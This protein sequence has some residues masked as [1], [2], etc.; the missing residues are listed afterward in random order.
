M[1]VKVFCRSLSFNEFLQRVVN[2]L[3]IICN[4]GC[5]LRRGV[6][7][8]VIYRFNQFTLDTEGYRLEADGKEIALEPLVFD[9]LVYL[10]DHRD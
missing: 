8:S 6:G 5:N 4:D 10:I 1:R 3:S 2:S 7:Y 9:L